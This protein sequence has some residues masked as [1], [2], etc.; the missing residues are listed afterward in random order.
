MEQLLR[1]IQNCKALY[2]LHI[3]PSQS[4]RI[5]AELLS[6]LPQS[7]WT[8]L[9]GMM[10]ESDKEAAPRLGGMQSCRCTG[11]STDLSAD[12]DLGIG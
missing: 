10:W 9:S 2:C 7:C 6:A 5:K 8:G 3:V 12:I 4:S 1:G 11:I